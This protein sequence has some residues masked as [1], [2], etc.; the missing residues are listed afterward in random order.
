MLVNAGTKTMDRTERPTPGKRKTRRR[1]ARAVRACLLMGLALFSGCTALTNPVADGIPVRLLPPELWG[2]S[3]AQLQPVPLSLLG[4]PQPSVHRLDSGDVLGV[5]ID[6]FLGERLQGVPLH[7]AP[8][9]D[10]REQ[11]RLPPAA[12]YP[13]TV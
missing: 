8:L 11:H 6:G 10:L 3:K 9:V 12:G 7:V 4:Q 13:V 2:P 5:Y 1:L